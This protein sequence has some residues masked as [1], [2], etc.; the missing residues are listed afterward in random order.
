MVELN[1]VG[2]TWTSSEDVNWCCRCA[3]RAGQV[4]D[5]ATSSYDKQDHTQTADAELVKFWFRRLPQ[6]TTDK[7]FENL[8]VSSSKCRLHYTLCGVAGEGG[9]KT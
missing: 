1:R 9:H 8:R 7:E 3:A 6:E 4:F 5:G 2:R